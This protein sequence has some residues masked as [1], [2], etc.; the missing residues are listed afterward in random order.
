MKPKKKL[1]KHTLI[2]PVLGYTFLQE[3]LMGKILEASRNINR[4]GLGDWVL[5]GTDAAEIYN[6]EISMGGFRIEGNSFV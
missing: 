1:K 2:K 4:S 6:S 3:E 5:M